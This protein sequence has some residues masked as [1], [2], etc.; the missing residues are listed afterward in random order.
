MNILRRLNWTN[1]LFLTLT[2]LVAVLG[3]FW[4]IQHGGI[5]VRTV[6][7]TLIFF[8]FSCLSITVG[9]HRLFSH[10]SYRA[11]WPVRLVLLLLSA[12]TFEGSALEWCTDHRRHHL[13]TDTDKDPYNIKRGFWYAHI[14]WL[15]VLDRSSRD[16]SNVADLAADP[17]IWLQHRFYVPLAITMGFV[18]PMLVAALWGDALSGLIIGG[19][20]R[21]TVTQHMTFCINSVC[22][23]V[24]R[25]TYSE[26]QSARDNWVTAIFT[27]GEGF[28]NFHHQFAIDYR[29]GIRA[30][31]FDPSKWLIALLFCLGL[32]KNLKRVSKE[33]IIRYRVEADERQLHQKIAHNPEMSMDTIHDF[34]QPLRDR[35]LQIAV[36]IGQLHKNYRALKEN[37][38][39]NLPGK[40]QRYR[41]YVAA[42]RRRIKKHQ[43]ELKEAL[44]VW[45][46]MVRSYR[47][48]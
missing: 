29:N 31:H 24:G 21:I 2:P 17:L 34:I 44:N 9:Y 36:A 26:K 16:M 32:A 28:H 40:L 25:Q 10:C 35:I 11:V 38:M 41:I 7:F 39:Q 18:L 45:K 43:T 37:K 4:L 48:S 5:D 22:H 27:F 6:W 14:G 47:I 12:A 13:Y 15:F 1:T 30:Y 33:Q 3:T 23:L 46:K 8:V 42:H 19:A 20:L